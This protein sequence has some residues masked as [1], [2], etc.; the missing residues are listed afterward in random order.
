MPLLITHQDDTEITGLSLTAERGVPSSTVDVKIKNTGA[1]DVVGAYLTLYT[2]TAPGSGIFVS[3]GQPPVDERMGRFEITGQ[4]STATPGQEIVLGQVQPMGH[5]AVAQLPTIKPGDWILGNFWIQQA[6]A[7]AG[8]GDINLKIEVANERLAYPLPIGVSKVGNGIDRGLNQ[9]RSYPIIGRHTTATGSPDDE[10]HVSAGEWLIDGVEF[11]DLTIQDVTLDQ[12]DSAAATLGSGES[13]IA[14]LTQGLTAVPTVTK[15]VKGATPARPT[16]PTGEL[17]LAWVTVDYN[18]G[19]GSIQP[20]DIEE[21]LVYSR[22]RVGAPPSGLAVM[23]EAGEAIIADFAQVRPNK[24]LIVVLASSTNRIWLEWNGAIRVT[25]SDDLPSAGAI[26]LAEAVTNAT[27]VTAL[28]DTR[29]YIQGSNSGVLE[30]EALGGSPNIPAV[31]KI[32][33]P[34]GAVTDNGGGEVEID[35]AAGDIT[36]ADKVTGLTATEGVKR[37]SGTDLSTAAALSMDVPGMTALGSPVGADYVPV[38][39]SSASAHRKVLVSDLIA[40]ASGGGAAG[41]TTD[42]AALTLGNG[43]NA[44][45]ALPISVASVLL[46]KADGITTS[47]T[48]SGFVAPAVDFFQVLVVSGNSGANPL[49]IQ[50]ANTG[51]TAGNRIICP[52]SAS[53]VLVQN[54]VAVLVYDFTIAKWRVVAVG[55]AAAAGTVTF[56][57]GTTAVSGVDSVLFT[58][59]GA[60]ITDLTGGAIEIDITPGGGGGGGTEIGWRL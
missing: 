59:G 55:K 29:R 49:T 37:A 38:Y 31:T 44:D 30:V 12:T 45:V 32:I 2:E 6:G 20:G 47:G 42:D 16:P 48:L 60:V 1:Q 36:K 19:G 10:V 41:F 35:L 26:K 57:D 54:D 18:A 4:D 43:A 24:G 33:F 7:S 27:D 56:D 58:G 13:Y 22:Y 9:A 52:G 11:E 46:L 50:H 15:G 17:I 28:T 25:Q 39:D 3:S 8:G 51:S 23:V 34:L 14:V 40:L 21:D 5:L 53:V